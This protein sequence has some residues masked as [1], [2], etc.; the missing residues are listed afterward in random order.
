M[1]TQ[2]EIRQP[3]SGKAEG[4]TVSISKKTQ[5]A[6]TAKKFRITRSGAV[7]GNGRILRWEYVFGSS[8]VV[9]E[10]SVRN[11]RTLAFVDLNTQETW[12]SPMVTRLPKIRNPLTNEEESTLMEAMEMLSQYERRGFY[13]LSQGL[14]DIFRLF[15]GS[16]LL[17]W[18]DWMNQR[19]DIDADKTEIN[20]VD[21]LL[22]SV[23]HRNFEGTPDEIERICREESTV[24]GY[25]SDRILGFLED[26]QQGEDEDEE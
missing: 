21:Y 13:R 3:K 25:A 24:W 7:E 5:T 18:T 17:S 16:D 22:R 14:S 6:Q 23:V 26:W 12:L 2:F 9:S 11:G 20:F 4:F 10:G 19:P 8:V 15:E 1:A